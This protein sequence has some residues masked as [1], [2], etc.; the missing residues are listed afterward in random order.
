MESEPDY[1]DIWMS[2][3]GRTDRENDFRA[4]LLEYAGVEL[5][6]E[7]ARSLVLVSLHEP[8]GVLALADLLGQNH[9]KTSRMLAQLEALGLVDRSRGTD[10]RIRTASTAAA[11]RTLIEQINQGRRRL[12]ADVF[13]DWT[14]ADQAT[15]ARLSQRYGDRIE[16][17]ISARKSAGA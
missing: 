4:L 13:R 15:F 5:D 9:P 11:G 6:A 10:Q 3:L 14:N 2:V 7:L 1:Y 17:L 16:E 12:L 8:I